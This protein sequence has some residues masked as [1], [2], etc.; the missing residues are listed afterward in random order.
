MAPAA[1]SDSS[2]VLYGL[3]A[4]REALRSRSRPLLR[5]LVLRED[6]QFA[7]LVRL[8]RAARVPVHIEPQQALD[9][10]V[11]HGR[12]Q[13][14]IAFA[15]AKPYAEPDDM[16]G[17]ARERRE[18]P[19]LVVLDGLEDPQNLGAICRT[20]E[21]A[22]VHGVVIP[23]RRSVGL[24]GAVAR[25]SAGALEHLLIG[26]VPNVSRLIEV[27]QAE[28]MWIYAVDPSAAKP[29]TALDL[30]GPLALVF[31]GEG[32]GIRPGVLD[33]CDDRARIPMHGRVASLNVSAA[34]A[35]V[36]FEVVRQRK[37]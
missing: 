35:I 30:K 17:I 25:A 36:L 1:G 27:L 5:I 2:G 4:V 13:G 12:H 31:G 11:P 14:A 33:K 16:L 28:G 8:A 19:F 3:H 15:A 34:A 23:E 10:L 20:A 22:G 37:G 32:K 6:R 29:Y 26:C 7:E 9:R 21:A 24:T 18:P